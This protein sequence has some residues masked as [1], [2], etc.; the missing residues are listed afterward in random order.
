VVA[1][2]A[3][4]YG[5]LRLGSFL[6]AEDSLQ[7]A[8]AIYVLAGTR[9]ER[10]L[11]AA[12]LY[13]AGYAPLILLSEEMPD[14]GVLVLERRGIHLP[15]TAEIARDT[16]VRLGVPATAV[17]IL[18]GHHDNTAHEANTL[19]RVAAERRWKRVIVVTSKFHT[20]RGG[21][22]MRRELSGTGVQ[23][24]V[25]ATRYDSSDPAHWWQTRDGL[26][27]TASEA[28]KLLAYALGLGM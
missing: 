26:R 16:L 19:R 8:D 20:R 12:E 7:R 28:Q 10:P 23:V 25:R 21:F 22:A 2:A 1:F 14:N 18:A 11:E 15:T 24:V 9:M 3:G 4:V 6:Y 17:E 13:L 5:C 27:W